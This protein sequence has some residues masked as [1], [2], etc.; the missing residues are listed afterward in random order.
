MENMKIHEDGLKGNKQMNDITRKKIDESL[1]NFLESIYFF[2]KHEE[3]I[4]GLKWDEIYLLQTIARNDGL[5]VTELGS[6][7]ETETFVVSRM[8]TKMEKSDL[9]KRTQSTTDRRFSHFS[10]SENGLKKIQE[11]EAFNYQV[12]MK[13]IEKMTPEQSE[14]LL[15][16]LNHLGDLL[17]VK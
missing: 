2:E 10:L 11:I 16:R 4:F 17:R 15:S 13:D 3:A 8:L 1:F 5:S 12:V 7:L 14:W 6:R 9:V